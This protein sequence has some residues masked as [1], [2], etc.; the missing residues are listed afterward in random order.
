[1]KIFRAR[2][3][4]N[5]RPSAVIDLLTDPEICALWSPVDFE[6]DDDVARLETGTQLEVGGR[7]AG[8]RVCFD[9]SILEAS[10][11]A[12]ELTASGPFEV[13]ARYEAREGR[14]GTELLAFVSVTGRGIRG[15]LASSAAEAMLAGGALK[16]A[17]ERIART[18]S[19]PAV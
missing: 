7:V 18:A 3:E 19:A 13:N 1:M 15:R 17:L 4:I 9:L 2:A 8:Q 16:H 14:D 12:F 10:R 5:A 11:R 6:V